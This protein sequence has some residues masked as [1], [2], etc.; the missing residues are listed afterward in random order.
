MK[1][2]ISHTIEHD[3]V[4]NPGQTLPQFEAIDTEYIPQSKAKS[5]VHP[6]WTRSQKARDS[7]EY[8]H[9]RFN[10]PVLQRRIVSAPAPAPNSNSA[11]RSKLSMRTK[12]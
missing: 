11:R 4:A 3:E 6:T 5:W 10:E 1:R 12:S 8:V 9:K 7:P 2:F